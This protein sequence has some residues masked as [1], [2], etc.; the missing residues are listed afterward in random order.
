MAGQITIGVD[1]SDGAREALR[2]GLAEARIHGAK[3]RVVHAWSIPAISGDVMGGFP[4]DGRLLDELADAASRLLD[5]ELAA[6]RELSSSLDIERV[7]LQG[8]AAESLVLGAEDADLLVVGSHGR[9]PLGSLFLG[10][11]SET[12]I[13]HAPCP[14]AVVHSFERAS[15]GQLV[16]GID[17]SPGSRAAFEWSVDEA[18]IRQAK[19]HAVVA[20]DDHWAPIVDRI[21][22]SD[23][24]VELEATVAHQAKRTLAT[25]IATAPVDVAVTG[26]T[27]RREPA[28]ALLAA[29]A[30]ADLL[31]VGSR[32]HGGVRS[33]LTGSVSRRCAAG[34]PRVTVVVPRAI[35][36]SPGRTARE[37]ATSAVQSR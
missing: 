19:L 26:E 36:R 20:Y 14:V 33:L 15:H 30:D 34:A 18:R 27:V 7:I 12:C 2:F 10:S 23:I 32:G 35:G 4:G 9:G 6:V 1:G 28:A 8:P 25:A 31:V 29:A 13:H 16:V 3:V 17:G 37:P 21:A 22:G 5:A 24:L 11:V